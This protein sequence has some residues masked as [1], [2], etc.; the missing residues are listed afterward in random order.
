MGKIIQFPGKNNGNND[1]NE[2]TKVRSIYSKETFSETVRKG[3]EEYILGNFA[4]KNIL[5]MDIVYKVNNNEIGVVGAIAYEH[6]RRPLTY[7]ADFIGKGFIDKK[8]GKVII[9]NLAFREGERELYN[10]IE[11][12]MKAKKILPDIKEF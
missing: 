6:K 7:I 1:K 10:S 9:D 3:V 5:G 4:V 12:I 11:K 8:S 2:E